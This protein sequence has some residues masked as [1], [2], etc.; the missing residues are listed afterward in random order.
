MAKFTAYFND[1]AIQSKIFDSGIVHIGR[2]ETNDF[3][4]DNLVVAPAH[5]VVI[6]KENN[7]IIKQLNDEFPLIINGIKTKET[8]LQNKDR[9]S[10]GKHILIF[11][12]TETIP[13]AFNNNET[14]QDIASLNNK[15][16]DK[17]QIPDANLQVMDGQH[18]GRILPLKKSMTRIGQSGSGIAIISRRK[19]GYFI[20]TLEGNANISINQKSLGEQTMPLT[21][22]DIVNIDNVS[23]QFFLEN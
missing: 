8:I 12:A 14:N 6:M 23:M 13:A 9:I 20:S 16:E 11:S 17:V 15:L 18:I 19:D 10:I 21:N 5:A 2:D 4:I 7:C 22:N 3:I 1:K